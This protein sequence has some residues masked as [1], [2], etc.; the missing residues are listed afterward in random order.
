MSNLLTSFLILS[1]A[2]WTHTFTLQSMHANLIED[3]L[4]KLK[5]FP[6]HCGC[7]CK[8]RVMKCVNRRWTKLSYPQ[9]V[10]CLWLHPWQVWQLVTVETLA[11]IML[12]GWNDPDS[13]PCFEKDP[14]L[15]IVVFLAPISITDTHTHTAQ[16]NLEVFRE[17]KR[18]RDKLEKIDILKRDERGKEIAA[19]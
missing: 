10:K 18:E 8:S 9:V 14:P 16:P 3:N 12:I 17:G 15:S 13:L 2:A 11:G 5:Y 6:V 1:A 19:E 4:V 7:L